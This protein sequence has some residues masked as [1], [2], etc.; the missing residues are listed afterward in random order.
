MSWQTTLDILPDMGITSK[1]SEGAAYVRGE[2][3]SQIFAVVVVLVLACCVC[4]ACA[5]IFVP[6][7]SQRDRL[8]VAT[9]GK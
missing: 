7:E 2:G 1:M 6:V 4:A 9:A 8:M 3:K 5:N